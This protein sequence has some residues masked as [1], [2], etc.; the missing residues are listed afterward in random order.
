MTILRRDTPALAMS[1]RAVCDL[2][3]RINT[4]DTDAGYKPH[5]PKCDG[6]HFIH[7]EIL[8]PVSMN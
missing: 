6:D 5:C 2:T 3:P 1:L 4:N 7:T 8:L